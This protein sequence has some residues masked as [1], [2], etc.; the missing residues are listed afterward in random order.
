[1]V[2]L[3]GL[4]AASCHGS[5]G[6]SRTSTP[7]QKLAW[8]KAKPDADLNRLLDGR[9]VELS[10]RASLVPLALAN[11]ERSF[12]AEIYS[13]DY[14]G[15]VLVDALSSRY[16]KIK[17]FGDPA[18]DQAAGQFDGRWLVWA[19]HHSL[20]SPDDFTVW[21]WDSHNGRVRQ[22]GAATRSPSG[23]FWPGA[24]QAPVAHGGYATWEQGAPTNTGEIHVVNL[25][26]GRD[27]I[28]R[29]G[30]VGG[31]LLVDGPR[32]IWPESMKPG[33]FTVMRTADATT[34][35]M[36]VT[37]P[38]LRRV[39][40]AIWPASNGKSLMYATDNQ[41][42]LWWSPSLDVAAKRVYRKWNYTLLGLPFDET[43]GRYT[44]F[45]VPLHT[46]LVDTVSGRYARILRG[47]WVITG[48]KSLVILEPAKAQTSIHA[49]VDVAFIPLKSLPPIPPC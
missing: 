17:R 10:R 27:R 48:P 47:G 4:L 20:R 15:V 37:P 23:E 25:A 11:G 12:F 7:A 36:L 32:V 33:A 38:A 22:I 42:S 13:K 9:V 5:N 18:T 3:I 26:S 30:D 2:V 35:R 14:S 39:R 1:V 8:C 40:G 24:L 29:R 31:P 34:G 16:K 44:T 46:Y 21:S 6:G 28:V 41:M 45:G 49:I 19:E 43:W